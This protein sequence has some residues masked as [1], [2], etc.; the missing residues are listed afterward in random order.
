[1]PIYEHFFLLCF[2]NCT[3]QKC[4]VVDACERWIFKKNVIACCDAVSLASI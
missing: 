4:V 3:E 2:L 1:M